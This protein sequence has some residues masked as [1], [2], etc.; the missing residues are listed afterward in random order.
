[1]GE[2]C[3]FVVRADVHERG[4]C[5]AGKVEGDSS[6]P[7]RS[8]RTEPSRRISSALRSPSSTE[9]APARLLAFG[10]PL[11]HVP[12]ASANASTSSEGCWRVSA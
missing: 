3:C 7:F 4:Q 10:I 6:I 5:L 9:S 1:M 8:A 11:D 12:S 2:S